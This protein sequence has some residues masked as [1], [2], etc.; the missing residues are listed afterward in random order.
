MSTA[1]TVGLHPNPIL[2]IPLISS[3]LTVFYAVVESTVLFP[4]LAAAKEDPPATNKVVRL[5]W[6][7]FLPPG[8]TTIFGI[9]IPTVV[10]GLY[11]LRHLR[12][13]S[14]KWKVCLAGS[15]FAAGHYA[16]VYSISQTIKDVMDEEVET[17]GTT[18]DHVKSWLKIHLW[19]TLTTDL[20]ALA[21]F[22]YVAFADE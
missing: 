22:G 9:T 17:K 10:S 19:R 20:P 13:Y 21:C 14:L 7:N 3:S 11:A 18:I 12:E 1:T 4:F 15:V 16:Y 8:L 5:W 2:T 6:T